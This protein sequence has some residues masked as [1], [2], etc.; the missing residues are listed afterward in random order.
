MSPN[1]AVKAWI[2]RDALSKP[3][4]IPRI[5]TTIP[6]DTTGIADIK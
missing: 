4:A 3:K 6:M 1:N 2:N 5:I